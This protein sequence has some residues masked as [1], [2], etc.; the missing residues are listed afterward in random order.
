MTDTPR[1]QAQAPPRRILEGRHPGKPVRWPALLLRH[2]L[3]PLT[4]RRRLA[5]HRQFRA[6][7]PPAPGAAR[8]PRTPGRRGPDSRF[9][10]ANAL[11]RVTPG[12]TF[13][14]MKDTPP[15]YSRLHSYIPSVIVLETHW[16]HHG[17]LAYSRTALSVLGR[18][19]GLGATPLRST[20]LRP[21]NPALHSPVFS[22]FGSLPAR[23]C[24]ASD[25]CGKANPR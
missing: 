7:R 22:W 21:R 5:Q 17:S 16:H 20:D 8:P 23:A 4:H 13:V 9:P 10:R 24:G 25:P 15:L 19:V 12:A 3:A 14:R 11:P 2:L 1:T 18:R 6:E